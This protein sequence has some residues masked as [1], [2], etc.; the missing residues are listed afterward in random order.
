MGIERPGAGAAGSKG[1]EAVHAACDLPY[2]PRSGPCGAVAP[3]GDLDARSQGIS[4]GDGRCRARLTTRLAALRRPGARAG[5]QGPALRAPGQPRELRPHLGDAI[6]RAQRRRARVGHALR[7]RQPAQAAAPDDRVGGGVGRPPD[8]D[9]PVA[10]RAQVPRRRAGARQGRGRE[11]HAL[12]GA[13]SPRSDDPRDPAGAGRRGRPHVPLAPVQAVPQAAPG[14]RQDQR[15]G[16]LH[17]ARANR[18]DRPVQADHR[19]RRL[20]PDDVQAERVAA[21]R[22]GG[23]RALRGLRAPR[24]AVLVA[25]RRQAHAGRPDRMG[26]AT[27]SGHRRRRAAER[28]GG[29]V[30]NPHPRPRASAEAERHQRRHRGPARQHRLVP[31]EPPLP[32]PS[33]TRRSGRRCSPP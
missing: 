22:A 24:R 20:R 5:D 29:L 15:A 9:L 27:R 31:D 4:R 23:L 26:R 7:H 14:A 16:G 25:R 1:R 21:G 2:P 28:R 8:L 19:V 3:Y 17:H 10:H 18:Q 11:P 33:T 12:V 6:R 13:R 30:G 32:P